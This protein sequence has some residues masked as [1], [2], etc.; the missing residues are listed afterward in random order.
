MSLTAPPSSAPCASIL[1]SSES[2]RNSQLLSS[3]LP[4]RNTNQ[5]LSRGDFLGGNVVRPSSSIAASDDN[6][7]TDFLA[8]MANLK[9]RSN[10]IAITSSNSD[11]MSEVSEGKANKAYLDK[12]LNSNLALDSDIRSDSNIESDF[13]IESENKNNNDSISTFSQNLQS[14]IN[15]ATNANNRFSSINTLYA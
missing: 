1:V 12:N 14:S 15:A 9:E 5:Q 7:Y 13:D 11:Q 8:A 4:Y 6:L 3:L 10:E 2:P